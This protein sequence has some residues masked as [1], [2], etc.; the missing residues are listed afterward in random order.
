M[1]QRLDAQHANA[2][3]EQEREHLPRADGSVRTV[4]AA[5]VDSHMAAFRHR[6]RGCP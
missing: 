2:P 4:D 5:S 6:L 3:A 1:R